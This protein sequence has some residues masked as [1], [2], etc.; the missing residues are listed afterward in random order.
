MG[1]FKAVLVGRD[2]FAVRSRGGISDLGSDVWEKKGGKSSDAL[3]RCIKAVMS[4]DVRRDVNE[5]TGSSPYTSGRHLTLKVKALAI[6]FT[7]TCVGADTKQARIV[8]D[9]KPKHAHATRVQFRG[10]GDLDY[11][12][13][14]VGGA[15]HSASN[16][17][18][19]F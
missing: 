19:R 1:C 18:S 14:E 3:H 9:L 6:R 16:T 17:Y 13:Q 5:Q 10:I 12:Q 11:Y 7:P 2:G 15:G 8:G 4:V